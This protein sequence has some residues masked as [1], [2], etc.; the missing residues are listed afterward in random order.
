MFWNDK[1]RALYF[2]RK[3]LTLN[4]ELPIISLSWLKYAVVIHGLISILCLSNPQI[5]GDE[6][7]DSKSTLSFKDKGKS[8]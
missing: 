1:Y 2:H 6:E 4:E 5:F 8:V 7:S 3:P